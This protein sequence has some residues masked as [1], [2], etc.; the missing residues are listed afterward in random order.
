MTG[1]VVFGASEAPADLV[2]TF[3]TSVNGANT[4]VMTYI[5]IALGAALGIVIT[6]FAVKKAVGFFKSMA[7]KG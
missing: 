1:I 2:S 3:T 4:Q 6:I 7:N 5:G